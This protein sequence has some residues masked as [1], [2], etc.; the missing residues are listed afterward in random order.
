MRLKRSQRQVAIAVRSR[1]R[2]REGG[3]GEQQDGVGAEA[4]EVFR[5]Q[6][7]A[8]EDEGGED[9]E[10]AGIPEGLRVDLC[11]ASGALRQGQGK[12]QT[13]GSQDAE[14]GEVDVAIVNEVGVHCIECRG[15]R[16]LRGR[17][18]VR[19]K[20]LFATNG[21]ATTKSNTVRST[22]PLGRTTKRR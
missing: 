10:K 4:L 17:P 5:D 3:N 12:D 11:A 7:Q 13:Q 16:T 20:I 14:G 22:D 2:G 6:D 8:R 9:G 15:C 18:A 19:D 1:P 21:S